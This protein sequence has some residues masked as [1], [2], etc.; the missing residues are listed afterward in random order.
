[1]FAAGVT[2]VLWAVVAPETAEAARLRFLRVAQRAVSRLTAPR[3]PIGVGEF[4]TRIAEGLDQL[5]GHLSADQPGDV[6]AL[7]A[8][9]RLLG[10]GRALRRQGTEGAAPIMA[11]G[12]SGI[13]DDYV[14]DLL[15][16]GHAQLAAEPDKQVH[17]DAA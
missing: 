14:A 9:M 8:G 2:L 10:A 4:E 17:R 6:A 13:S 11:F 16:R 1:V 12:N 15:K 3:H 5:Q 7:Q